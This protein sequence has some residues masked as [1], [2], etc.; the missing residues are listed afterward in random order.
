MSGRPGGSGTRDAVPSE[1]P[2]RDAVPSE[3]PWLSAWAD[4]L[5]GS[6]GF[7]LRP[8]GPAGHFRTAAHASTSGLLASALA[9]LAR[10]CG[11]DT[12]VD[13]G[14]GRGELLTSLLAAD[15][16]LRLTGV[17]HAP[18]PADLPARIGWLPEAPDRMTATLLVGWEL[19]DVVPCPVLEV[20]D[21]GL[22]REVLTRPDGTEVLGG[23]AAPQDGAWTR[24]WWPHDAAPGT[25]V[26]VGSTRDT[27]WS[28]LVGR[29]ADGVALAVDYGHDADDRPPLGT[30]TGF[31]DGQQVA[32]RADGSTDVTAHVA[33]D[34]LVDALHRRAG[35]GGDGAS[36]DRL[37]TRTTQR[38]ALG[39]LGVSGRRPDLALASTDPARY[40]A[41]LQSAG[42]AAELRD[43][44]GLGG[45][46]WVLTAV[47][48]GAVRGVRDLLG[49]PS[50]PCREG[51]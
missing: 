32:P 44:G 6:G 14:A 41:L 39:L 19:L 18:R 22:L 21:D 15:P 1:R 26:E 2:S 31:R 45:F 7:Y 51:G 38:E 13:V 3:R 35:F 48:A 29:L 33:L 37:T 49:H 12:V 25:R 36:A 30:L 34:S 43:A 11:C 8:E 40:L 42:E 24:R 27:A 23:P 17:D 10:R 47:G 50:D 16:G 28:W 46:G 5:Y 4:A 9:T 20:D